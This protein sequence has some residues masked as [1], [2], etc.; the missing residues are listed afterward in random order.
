MTVK[1]FLERWSLYLLIEV[2][3]SIDC[4]IKFYGDQIVCNLSSNNKFMNRGYTKY[5]NL[6]GNINCLI[7]CHVCLSS[8]PFCFAVELFW[9]SLVMLVAL[10]RIATA[11]LSVSHISFAII[12]HQS[13]PSF[14][15]RNIFDKYFYSNT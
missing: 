2:Y 12:Q 3:K 13:Q 6:I 1:L 9:N 10:V 11:P 14:S 4:S 7:I 8:F 15:G 5:L